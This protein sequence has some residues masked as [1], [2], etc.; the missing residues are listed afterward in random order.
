M[1][2]IEAVTPLTSQLIAFGLADRSHDTIFS[3][4]R[5]LQMGKLGEPNPR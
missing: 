5:S 3:V 2:E 4:Q 1:R